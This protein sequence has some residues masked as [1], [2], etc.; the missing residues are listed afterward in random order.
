[1][2]NIDVSIQ[3]S[4]VVEVSV[5]E[6]TPELTV[7]IISTGPQG[8]QGEQGPQGIQ[9]IQGE[10]G[11]QGPKGEDG[12]ATDE[13][14][15]AAVAAL[16]AEDPSSVQ[17]AVDQ[18]LED[19]PTVGGAFSNAAKYAL[20]SLLEKVAY[21][22]E[23]GQEYWDTLEQ[24]LFTVA[25]SS[26]AAVYTQSGTVYDTDSLDSLRDDLVVTA[27]FVDGTSETVT[28]YTLSGTLT[29]GTSAITVTYGGKTTT[30]NVIVKARTN[31]ATTPISWNT[32]S[33]SYAVI[34]GSDVQIKGNNNGW[35]NVVLNN[36]IYQNSQTANKQVHIICDVVVTGLTSGA[37]D[38]RGMLYPNQNP[39]TLSDAVS[40][41]SAAFDPTI[42]ID[43]NGTYHF[44]SVFIPD[45]L[46]KWAGKTGYVGISLMASTANSAATGSF[47]NIKIYLEDV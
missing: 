21:I 24:E 37:Y 9:G 36:L 20:L 31:L 11:P 16:I 1:M 19:H 35:P 4:Q 46:T 26:I 14:V 5:T 6:E 3:E 45:N 10:T 39:T 40:N 33:G 18:Y 12:T 34:S 25:V 32:A 38:I 47:T 30:F 7:Q 2:A 44:D 43:A 8:I 15:E 22:D 13:Q 17:D 23:N 41:T 42:H 28:T 27:D 29:A